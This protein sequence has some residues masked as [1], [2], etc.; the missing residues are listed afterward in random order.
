[1]MRCCLA[2]AHSQETLQQ[3]GI[4]VIHQRHYWNFTEATI[5][6]IVRALGAN[7]LTRSSPSND[8]LAHLYPSFQPIKSQLHRSTPMIRSAFNAGPT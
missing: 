4:N 2:S 6:E 7:I 8:L 1:M 5:R 3:K